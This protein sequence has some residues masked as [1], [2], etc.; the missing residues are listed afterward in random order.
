MCCDFYWNILT[1]KSLSPDETAPL[2]EQG[3]IKHPTRGLID[4]LNIPT[5]REAQIRYPATREHFL[6]LESEIKVNCSW[7]FTSKI[8]NSDWE[9]KKDAGRNCIDVARRTA[10]KSALLHAR[11]H[12]GLQVSASAGMGPQWSTRIQNGLKGSGTV[13]GR[14]RLQG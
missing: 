12:I 1:R 7:A 13:C 5:A 6:R 3:V 10:E 4:S 9:S 2:S 11:H 8:A 14:G